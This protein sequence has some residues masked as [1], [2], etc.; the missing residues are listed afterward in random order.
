MFGTAPLSFN[1]KKGKFIVSFGWKCY[2]AIV[3]SL[4]IVLIYCGMQRRMSQLHITM[5]DLVLPIDTFNILLGDV[6]GI[7][8]IL[9][10]ISLKQR[11][12]DMW[13]LNLL[14]VDMFLHRNSEPEYFKISKLLQRMLFMVML[15]SL[16]LFGGYMWLPEYR[17]Q[18]DLLFPFYFC[19]GVRYAVTHQFF[20]FNM[21]LYRKF[22]HL[23]KHLLDI[24][25]VHSEFDLDY[26]ISPWTK[27]NTGNY[28][29][30]FQCKLHSEDSCNLTRRERLENRIKRKSGLAAPMTLQF[31]SSVPV[32]H[33]RK[34]HCLLHDM[35]RSVSEAFGVQIVAEVTFS[36]LNIV[37][38][39][40]VMLAH[41]LRTGA[42][43]CGPPT[44]V[45]LLACLP[46]SVLSVCRLAIIACS[47]ES[48]VQESNHTLEL[49]NKLLLLPSNGDYDR[50]QA[51][52]KFA[53][54]LHHS[55][56]SYSAAGL[57]SIDRSLI[58]SCVA[59]ITTYL[60]ILIQFSLK[61]FSR[62]QRNNCSS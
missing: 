13:C 50:R 37:M 8:L 1:D 59:T 26:I 15:L 47:S 19:Y 12:V 20:A 44:G 53:H 23:N 55:R 25:C 7:V 18:L 5:G 35:T 22:L 42:V 16:V 32:S 33:I 48:V 49:V 57:F 34:V 43:S 61:K 41:F 2:S 10:S 62:Q 28:V 31:K 46:W 54:Q 38:N 14:S 29:S 21:I 58:T 11:C 52:Q 36:F 45:V 4:L 30:E 39:T 60:V 9:R 56:L 27:T 51:L 6:S 3:T 40:Y 17:F 24:F